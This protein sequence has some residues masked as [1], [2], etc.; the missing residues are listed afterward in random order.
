MIEYVTVW[1][2]DLPDLKRGEEIVRCSDCVWS[3]P[4]QS[5]HEHRE[6]HCNMWIAD[7]SAEGF[8][9]RGKRNDGFTPKN[10]ISGT[11]VDADDA[12]AASVSV[13]RFIEAGNET[14]SA[15]SREKLEADVRKHYAYS[16]TTL[17]YP[18]SA[19]KTTDMLG[20]LPVDTVIGWLDRQASITERECM[21]CSTSERVGFDCAECAEGLGRELDARCDPLKARIAEL[22]DQ[23][24]ELTAERDQWRDAYGDS[25][26]L[27]LELV[28][29][30]EHAR[31][32]S[33]KW[34]DLVRRYEG[35]CDGLLD[36]R[37]R[38]RGDAS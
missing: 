2:D 19:N 29:D 1:V 30:L 22:C 32:W 14:G 11:E 23:V 15:D 3:K 25:E 37:D 38:L 12:D 36:E 27:R 20:A 28:K 5:D 16:T 18:S 6:L 26:R 8:C 24:D 34:R 21:E 31:R 10:D 17:M 4:D 33:D 13:S 7:V 35:L 9:S